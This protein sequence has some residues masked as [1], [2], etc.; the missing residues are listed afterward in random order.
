MRGH[1]SSVVFAGLV[2]GGTMLIAQSARSP[3]PSPGK[4]AQ[5]E[6]VRSSDLKWS[7]PLN[8]VRALKS[9]GGSREGRA[10]GSLI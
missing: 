3:Q 8:K 5:I 9:G 2:A 1:T 6:I 4:D 7:D 10:A